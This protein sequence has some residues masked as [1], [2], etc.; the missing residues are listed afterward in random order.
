MQQDP[1]NNAMENVP[2]E[3]NFDYR[4]GFANGLEAIHHETY[5]SHLAS[6]VH[7][8]W[9]SQE[10]SEKKQQWQQL[11]ARL[12][13]HH[14]AT[15]Q[16]FADLQDRLMCIATEGQRQAYLKEQYSDNQSKI[17]QIETRLEASRHRYSLL[18]G[19]VYWV[20][21][22]AFVAGDL[23]ISHEIVAY[24]LNIRN[25]TEAWAFAFGLAM[26]SVLLK[27]VYD[28]L[29]EKPY[30]EK[31]QQ[32]RGYAWFKIALMAFAV[33]TLFVL[34]YFRY[35]AYKTDRLKQAVNQQIKTLQQQ[36]TDPLTGQLQDSAQL[37]AQLQAQRAKFEQ[38]NQALVDSPWAL[39]AFVLSG[40]L[41]AL[42]GAVC[43]GIAF[44]VLQCYWQRW[45]QLLPARKKLIAQREVLQ[46]DI[47][48]CSA[49]LAQYYAQRLTLE[50][51]LAPDERVA[52][53]EAQ[54]LQLE[55][56]IIELSEK[57]RL[58]ETDTR[59]SA[60]N[61]GYAKGNSTRAWMSDEEFQQY[62]LNTF[63]SGQSSK[64]ASNNRAEKQPFS[65]RT[66]RPYEE[67]RKQ[68]WGDLRGDNE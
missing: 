29:V 52:Q 38:L 16:A 49:L 39:W 15:R 2:D 13:A 60:F 68:I 22:L 65:K 4:H 40:I 43:W 7:W 3:D 31:N 6:K 14:Q 33:A 1:P 20:A 24:A 42:A 17:A 26:V 19:L 10:L 32:P 12:D 44:P 64:N 62:K 58:A 56:N 66:G 18:A 63:A 36:A 46:K 41:F 53:W 57:C 51:D 11:Q 54:V 21:G 30:L 27:P 47:Q 45:L 37:Q 50:R 25:T 34:G 23:I 61:D 48:Q 5:E 59:I 35:E 28:R 67:F 8:Q 9:M 55:K